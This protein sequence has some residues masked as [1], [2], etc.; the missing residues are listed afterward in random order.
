MLD[1]VSI[2]VENAGKGHSVAAGGVFADGLARRGELSHLTDL[3]GL[4][5][6]AAGV[7]VNLGV[8]DHDIHVFAGSEHVVQTAETDIIGPAVAAEDPDGLLGQVLLL[9]QN[10]SRKRAGLAVAGGLAGSL[11]ALHMLQKKH[12]KNN[13][14]K[15]KQ[16]SQHL[17]KKKPNKK[18]LLH[19]KMKKVHQVIIQQTAM[20]VIHHKIQPMILHQMKIQ[21]QIQQL[22]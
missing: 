22:K 12:N 6:L 4:G 13:K 18:N 10:F 21:I 1:A 20:K 2:A 8:K 3:A 9:L 5:G 11:Q 19:L 16:T 17:Q 14:I 15:Q 7:G